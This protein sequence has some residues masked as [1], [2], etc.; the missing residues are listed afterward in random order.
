RPGRSSADLRPG[1]SASCGLDLQPLQVAVRVAEVLRRLE[2]LHDSPVTVRSRLDLGTDR[3][4][5]I[6]VDRPELPAIAGE[7]QDIAFLQVDEASCGIVD[8]YRRHS[9]Q[10]ISAGAPHRID[11]HEYAPMRHRSLRRIGTRS[12]VLR[13]LNGTVA[14]H[15]LKAPSGPWN[16]ADHR[17]PV[18]D[19]RM[20]GDELVLAR[21]AVD[22]HQVF[23]IR[24]RRVLMAIRET[25]RALL[26]P[27]I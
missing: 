1:S 20:G 23:E 6:H 18:R 12:H 16:E 11:R 13:S 26:G 24:Y 10:L 19:A 4:K 9:Q 8:W 14:G 5:L 2:L 7:G 21:V 17:H 3:L 15:H 25:L 22:R 27:G